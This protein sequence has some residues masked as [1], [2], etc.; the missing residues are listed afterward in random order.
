MECAEVVQAVA[1][2]SFGPL[3]PYLI[4]TWPAARLM[5]DAGMKKGEILRGPPAIMAVCS[6][7]MTSNPPMPEP[8]WTPIISLFSLVTCR[9]EFSPPWIGRPHVTALTLNRLA[10]RDIH[11]LIEGVIGNRSLP[12][13]IRQDII[14]RTDGIPLFVEE[15]TKAVLEA[16][17][18]D[19]A[20]RTAG[21][22]PLPA[23]AVPATLQASLMAR[24]DRLGPAK[25]VAQ[26]G[27][28]L[29]RQVDRALGVEPLLDLK[30]RL[31]EGT[32]AA[33]AMPVLEA[34]AKVLCEMATFDTANVSG[35]VSD[36]ES[37]A[38][39]GTGH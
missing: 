26:I 31:G 4:E 2:A 13:D 23:L 14:E 33:L 1:V 34:A 18:E 7:S 15:M 24:L 21:A 17:S 12:A 16:E 11:S 32:G 3:A 6:R 29:G 25:E 36:G 39:Y 28:A 19:D 38:I 9:P 27:A 22:I 30:M 5:I 10:R 35:A 37:H 20:R 8:M